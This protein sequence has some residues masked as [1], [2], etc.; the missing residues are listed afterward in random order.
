MRLKD[1]I[2]KATLLLD[3]KGEKENAIRLLEDSLS[4]NSK[5]SYVVDVI[6]GKVFLGE[7]LFDAEKFKEAILQL[8][9]SIKI[10]DESDFE[11]D[12]VE[13]EIKRA[14]KLISEI[15]TL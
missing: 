8:Q 1:S 15:K 10:F 9:D 12:L 11:K 4:E 6:R 13:T 7:L 5:D 3:L 14:K 2:H